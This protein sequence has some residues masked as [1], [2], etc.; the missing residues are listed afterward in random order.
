VVLSGDN[1]GSRLLTSG[2]LW[3]RVGPSFCSKSYGDAINI[4]PECDNKYQFSTAIIGESYHVINLAKWF[5]LLP[6]HFYMPFL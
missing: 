3:S 1:A 5:G 4:Y 6:E 2:W